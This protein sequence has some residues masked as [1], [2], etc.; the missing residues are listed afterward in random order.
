MDHKDYSGEYF[1]HISTNTDIRKFVPRLTL[2]GSELENRDITRIY[3][4]P[5]LLGC[6]I[7]YASAE[8]DFMSLESDG[9][10][11]DWKGGYKIYELPFKAALKPN[12]AMVH[13]QLASDEHWMVTYSPDTIDYV[14]KTAGRIFFDSVSYKARSKKR[15]H[16]EAVWFVEVTKDEG[17]PFGKKHFLA[18]GYWRVEG[19][20]TM[21][22]TGWKQDG[23]FT[24]TKIQKSEYGNTKELRAT[25][26]SY[27]ETNNPPA[28]KDW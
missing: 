15:P 8:N 7:G 12:T 10:E 1:L 19:P 25:L 17:I 28:Y 3:V 2:R 26:L 5:T 22:A 23:E 13:D 21:N 14:P 11:K 6:L 4:A 16:G 24:V 20:V 27:Q 9:K 18:K